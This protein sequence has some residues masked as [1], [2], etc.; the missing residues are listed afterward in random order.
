MGL[1][2]FFNNG[3]FFKFRV[4]WD[5]KQGHHEGLPQ[6]YARTNQVIGAGAAVSDTFP[7]NEGRIFDEEED[8]RKAGIVD[9][10]IS[11]ALL[12]H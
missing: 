3:W 1:A 4:I 2:E 7:Y 5:N 9:T 12:P 10:M 11:K 8:E 6:I